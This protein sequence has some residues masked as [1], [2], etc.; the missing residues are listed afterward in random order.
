[1]AKIKRQNTKTLQNRGDIIKKQHV[2]M[3]YLK[4]KPKK[5]KQMAVLTIQKHLFTGEEGLYQQSALDKDVV[6]QL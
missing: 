4:K 5:T 2:K 6:T 1:V 3:L